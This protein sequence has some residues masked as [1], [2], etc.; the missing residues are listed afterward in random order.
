MSLLSPVGLEPG[1]RQPAIGVRMVWPAGLWGIFFHG[2]PDYANACQIPVG[3]LALRVLL[4]RKSPFGSLRPHRRARDGREGE[5]RSAQ[6][7]L[8]WG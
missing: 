6:I 4:T 3:N 8:R 2:P 7:N 5:D 1:L